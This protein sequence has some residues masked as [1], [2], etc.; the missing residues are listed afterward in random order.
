MGYLGVGFVLA[1]L[2]ILVSRK[3]KLKIF[4]EQ[5]GDSWERNFLEFF[6]LFAWPLAILVGGVAGLFYLLYC[7]FSLQI[8]KETPNDKI[9]DDLS[10]YLQSKGVSKLDAD[11]IIEEVEKS[12]LNNS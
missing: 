7:V 8:R 5:S 11:H 4:L 2:A 3:L 12:K 6:I 9:G 10:G 1:L